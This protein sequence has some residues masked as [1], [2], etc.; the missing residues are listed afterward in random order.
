LAIRIILDTNFLFIPSQFHIDVFEELN[1]L[2]GQRVE[3][4]ILSTTLRELE[5]LVQS[6]S[7]KKSKQASL[8]LRLAE[9]CSVVEVRPKGNESNDDVILRTAVNMK[10]P[11]ATND[12]ELRKRLRKAGVSVIFLRGKSTLAVDGSV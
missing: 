3:P 9:K 11:V 12:Q 8:G 6:R 1:Q 7:V 5:K 2:M 4:L 10:C